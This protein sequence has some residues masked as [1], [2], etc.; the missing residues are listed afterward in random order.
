M[1]TAL[2]FW[3]GLALTP[4]FADPAVESETKAASARTV[5]GVTGKGVA[6]AI[7]D[8]GIDW[9]HPDFLNG[10]GTTR[11]AYIF[12]LTDNAGATAPNNKY[13]V[14]T[15]YTKAQID[16]AL[17]GGTSL[18]TRDAVGHGTATAGNCCGNG[19]ASNGKYVGIAPETTLI[20]VKITSDGAP[21]HDDQ[22]AEAAFWNPELFPDAVDFSIE[23]ARELGMPLVMLANFGSVGAQA[24]GTDSFAQKIDSVVGPGK[25]GVAFITGTGDDGGR[26]NHASGTV[27]SGQAAE[28]KIQKGLAGTLTFQLWYSGN[29]RF[30]IA[31]SSPSKTYGPYLAPANSGFDRQTTSEFTY[32]HNGSAYYSNFMRVVYLQL[33][34]P[35]GNYSVNLSGATLDSG[36][37]DAYLNPAYYF[38]KDANQFLTFATSEKT[39]W[40]GATARYAIVPNSYVFRTSWTDL[41]G[42]SRSVTGEGNIGELWQGSS[43]GPTWDGRYG[44]DVSA[45]GDRN[46]TTYGRSS[47]W[48][49][50]R[51]NLVADGAGYYGVASAV[52]A[53]NPIVTGIVAL[54]LQKNP[55][56][57]AATLKLALQQTARADVNTGTIPN[58]QYGYG[59]V[60]A[61]A[62]VAAVDPNKFS[63][64]SS[65]CIFNWAERNYADIFPPP[66]S[67]SATYLPY[68]YRYYS[69][70]GNFLAT[71]SADNHIWVLG[72]LF[73][74]SPIDVAP[75]SSLLGVAGCSQ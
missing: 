16:S 59:K 35:T 12:D 21:A 10:D 23:K 68:Y 18:S 72:P 25:P 67:S 56:A 62:A 8:R 37:F 39:I 7:F 48:A 27:R 31:I 1:A 14:G 65:D 50:V 38:L 69:G 19:R 58:T 73:G 49:T 5:Y 55:K 20:V 52:S 28:I 41:D 13:G 51:G 2:I 3:A 54:M 30:D 11:I 71:S 74:A 9:S 61:L 33:T 34:G 26:N 46:I 29:D 70:K 57:D 47:Y 44:V 24:D 22:T 6:V 63:A 40:S 64:A 45:P 43:V 32:G 53:A 4:A 60:D 15:I 75:I 36:R 66:G 17:K 42:F